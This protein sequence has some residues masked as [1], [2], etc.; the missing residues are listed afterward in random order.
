LITYS[1]NDLF[2]LTCTRVISQQHNKVIQMVGI[3]NLNK[4]HVKEK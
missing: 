3:L 2:K 1:F 4:F